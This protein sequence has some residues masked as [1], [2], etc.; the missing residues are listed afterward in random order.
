MKPVRPGLP[1]A[2]ILIF[3]LGMGS[4]V[5]L[6]VSLGRR[7]AREQ[8]VT[9]RSETRRREAESRLA[10]GR[11]ELREARERLA[12]VEAERAAR[13]RVVEGEMA[14]LRRDLAA[15]V[16]ERDSLAEKYRAAS[17]ERDRTLEQFLAA[18]SALE[19]TRTDLVRATERAAAAGESSRKAA[20][21]AGESARE[22]R[23]AAAGDPPGPPAA[24]GGESAGLPRAAAERVVFLLRPLLQDLRSAD[25]AVRVRAHEALC[26]WTGRDLT[27]RPN[28]TAEE[29]EADAAALER[30]LLR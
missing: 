18:R 7:I 28:G 14:V 22:L 4:G 17:S 20:A 15:A 8:E 27:F 3:L 25:R 1:V 11:N 13:S 2:W 30:E 12:R 6:V 10:A 9:E 24:G 21:A 23:A 26:N 5:V 19:G 29:V 16:K